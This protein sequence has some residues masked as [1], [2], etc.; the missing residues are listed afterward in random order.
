M[1]P[2]ISSFCRSASER[3][4]FKVL[5]DSELQKWCWTLCFTRM[6]DKLKRRF[7]VLVF[8]DPPGAQVEVQAQ[9]QAQ[10]LRGPPVAQQ[11]SSPAAQPPSPLALLTLDPSSM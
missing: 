11:P 3:P 2:A 1:F 4:L 7:P 5:E 6:N 10:A 9:A 8:R